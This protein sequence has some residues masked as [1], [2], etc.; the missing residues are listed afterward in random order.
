MEKS[1][2]ENTK[3]Q[4]GLSCLYLIT[5]FSLGYYFLVIKLVYIEYVYQIVYALVFII[6]Y[7]FIKTREYIK[8]TKIYYEDTVSKFNVSLISVL[9]EV[10]GIVSFT[11]LVTSLLGLNNLIK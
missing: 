5:S 11:V 3:V 7:V 1:L 4:F 2:F 8:T 10:F 6:I 9:T